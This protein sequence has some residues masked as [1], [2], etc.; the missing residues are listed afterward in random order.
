MGFNV[1][2]KI[3][4]ILADYIQVRT[5]YVSDTVAHVAISRF[6]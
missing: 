5:I 3:N 2:T 4:T 1:L 6:W